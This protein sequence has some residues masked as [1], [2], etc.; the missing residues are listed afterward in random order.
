ML[1]VARMTIVAQVFSHLLVGEGATEPGIP[2]E[3]H[4]H[5]RDE[6]CGDKKQDAVAGG[7]AGTLGAGFSSR[8]GFSRSSLGHGCSG[9][10]LVPGW[11]TT[12]TPPIGN[13]TSIDDVRVEHTVL[14]QVVGE[15]VLGEQGSLDC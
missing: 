12:A 9:W 5:E 15:G 4:G 8:I 3:P 7:H 1:D 10:S 2:P 6:P 13:Y 14:F 11:R